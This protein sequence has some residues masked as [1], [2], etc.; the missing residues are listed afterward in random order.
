[1][2]SGEF[3]GKNIDDLLIEADKIIGE[4]LPYFQMS[5]NSNNIRS[6]EDFGK[7][8]SN[9]KTSLSKSQLNETKKVVFNLKNNYQSIPDKH[10]S[11]SENCG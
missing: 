2:I 1:M 9:V 8:S 4:T 6:L 5:S 10:R 11:T 7:V 3:S